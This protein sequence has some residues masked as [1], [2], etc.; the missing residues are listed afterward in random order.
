MPSNRFV[1]RRLRNSKAAVGNAHTG[2]GSFFRSLR[3]ECLNANENGARGISN[4][5]AIASQ[6]IDLAV[7]AVGGRLRIGT[8]GWNVPTA[9]I[10]EFPTAGSHLERYA[11]RLKCVEINSSFCRPHQKKTYAR[12]ARSTPEAFRFAVKLPQSIS[13]A[14]DLQFK[15][16]ELERLALDV[17]G[18]G[19]KLSVLLVQFPPRLAFDSPP[20]GM[21]FDTLRRYF[22]HSIACEP[23]HASWFAPEVDQWMVRRQIAR[24]AADPARA[25]GAGEPGGWRRF[26]YIRLMPVTTRTPWLPSLA[27]PKFSREKRRSGALST[28]QPPVP[29]WITR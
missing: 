20:A 7:T 5:E 18:L 11:A 2:C 22:K 10:D 24:V 12:W 9:L 13:H 4:D 23:R 1:R 29:H 15:L 25:D 8:A 16:D 21:L 28:I 3:V 19:T 26:F 6:A 14:D 27:G 17:E